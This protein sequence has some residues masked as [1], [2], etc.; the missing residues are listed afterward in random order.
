[1]PKVGKKVD[2]PIKE[3][4]ADYLIHRLTILDPSGELR[5]SHIGIGN[6]ILQGRISP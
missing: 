2:I 6:R 4:Q 1:M 5:S 3:L